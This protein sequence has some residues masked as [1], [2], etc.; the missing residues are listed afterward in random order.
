MNPSTTATK[1]GQQPLPAGVELE[2][3]LEELLSQDRFPP[4]AGFLS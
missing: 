2:R 3:R 1:T 4:P